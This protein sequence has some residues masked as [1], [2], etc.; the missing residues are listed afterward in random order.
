MVVVRTV[1]LALLALTGLVL[2]GEARQP[3]TL[4]DIRSTGSVTVCADPDNLPFSSAEPQWPGYD[5]EVMRLLATE[6]GARAEFKWISTQSARAAIRNLLNG[7][8]D[9]FP[10]LPLSPGFAEEYPQLAFSMAYYTM[11]HGIVTRSGESV[12]GPESLKTAITAVEALSAGDL[13][14]FS[15]GYR[16]RTYRTQEA[17]FH[18][19]QSGETD[20]AL[21]WS[22]IAG[23][24]A[25]R[26]GASQLTLLRLFD[27]DLQVAFGVGLL[28]RDPALRVAVNQGIARLLARGTVRDTLRRYGAPSADD[29]SSRRRAVTPIGWISGGTVRLFFL[30]QAKEEEPDPVTGRL[31]FEANCEQC[32][33]IDGRGGG[34]VPRLQ[35]YPLGAEPRFVQTVLEGRNSRGM[36][37]WGGLLTEWQVRSMF[38][39]VHA[40][41]PQ[42]EGAANAPGEE[43]ARQIF[44]QVCATCHGR[45]GRGTL[46]A[47]SLQAFKGGDDDFV[48][49]VLNGRAGTAMAPF[50][51]LVSVEVA[52]KIREYVRELA[53]P[54]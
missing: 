3:K 48:N 9:L 47:P 27:P 20:A 26:S 13:F 32:H 15:K 19:V 49:T 40:L 18:A 4:T 29:R 43:Q 31:L 12:N 44:G 28:R 16:R 46:I 11:G 1:L 2:T 8:C 42:I 22:P 50:K 5:V 39:Y 23:W 24:L 54:N 45:E 25:K 52:R 38:A 33:G 34:A 36:P 17:A 7:E 41:V 37:P 35:A 51:G 6:L 10:G 53:R 21:L 30:A 14:L